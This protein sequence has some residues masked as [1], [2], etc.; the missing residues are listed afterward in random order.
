LIPDIPKKIIYNKI[1]SAKF[2]SPNGNCLELKPKYPV[3]V[4]DRVELDKFLFDKV[5]NKIEVRTGEKFESFRYIENSLMIKTNKES[6]YS[7]VLIGADGPNSI[8]RKQL[9]IKPKNFLLGLQTTVK[10]E[11]NPDSVELWFGP[12][13][14]PNFF[15][16]V[17]PLDETFA[18]V[19]IATNNNVMK[20]FDN[21]LKK[22][23][24]YIKK[25]DVVGKIP[26]GLINRSSGDRIMLAGDAAFQV[27]PFSGGGI[28]YGLIASEVCANT[29]IK[30][31]EENRFDKRFFQKNYDNLWKDKLSLPIMK[32]L[33]LR[34]VFNNLPDSLL[35]ILFYSVGHSKKI[36]ENWDMDL[37]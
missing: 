24:G 8:I 27:K 5:K 9:G 16:W 2:F 36:L 26:Y 4:I 35:D 34:K 28:V 1:K 22:R 6:Y 37:L 3:Y 12:K 32:G 31:I 19:G 10:G 15:A 13:I 14:C 7:K 11:F 17:V 23:I 30:S 21:F 18:R 20:F 29:A 25:P 33:I